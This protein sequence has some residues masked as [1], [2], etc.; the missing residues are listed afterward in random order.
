[1]LSELKVAETALQALGLAWLLILGVC[2][3]ALA[4]EL[5]LTVALL[6]SAFTGAFLFLSLLLLHFG[7]FHQRATNETQR[8]GRAAGGTALALAG[9]LFLAGCVCMA[10]AVWPDWALCWQDLNYTLPPFSGSGLELLHALFFRLCALETGLLNLLLLLALALAVA[11]LNALRAHQ[12]ASKT[13][14]AG[15]GAAREGGRGAV[16][17]ARLRGVHKQRRQARRRNTGTVRHS[18]PCWPA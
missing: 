7:P 14:A 1:M 4:A 17:H 12:A 15:W 5:D 10:P 6:L 8:L 13:S 2:G 9:V 18:L 11:A 16:L 3:A